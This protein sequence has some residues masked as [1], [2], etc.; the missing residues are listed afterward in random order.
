MKNGF[1]DYLKRHQERSDRVLE[2]EFAALEPVAP[3]LFEAMHYGLFGNGKRIRPV[4]AYASAEAVGCT[5]P[6]V[7]SVAC[8]V[9]CIH[10]YS[11]VHDD[12]PAMDDDDLRRGRPT[13]H[14][15]FD[16][17]TAVLA[18]DSLHTLAF[19][20]L[21]KVEEVAPGT[22]LELIRSLAKA[23]GSGGMVAGQ[24]LDLSAVARKLSLSELENMHRYKTG[25]LIQASVRMGA[26][27]TEKASP[28]QLFA[29][30]RYAQ[31]VGLAFQ[32]QDDIL[33]VTG[34]TAVMGKQQG[35]DALRDKP[36]YVSLLGLDRARH[37]ARELHESALAA[38][39]EFDGRADALRGLSAYIVERV[40]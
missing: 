19:H 36:T 8:A 30:D 9:E 10:A 2:R 15:A 20:V 31:C 38:L 5:G 25:A 35:A 21:A 26:I 33:D 37:K 28:E 24:A 14:I 12:L 7:D 34:N 16:E 11:L 18:G 29:L 4:L 1:Q 17:A 3:R 27:A 13:C 23:S 22:A 6:A 39:R 32:V 40:S